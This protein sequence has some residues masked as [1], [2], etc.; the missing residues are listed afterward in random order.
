[1]SLPKRIRTVGV[2]GSGVMGAQIAAHCANAGLNVHLLDL[3]S[4]KELQPNALVQESLKKLTQMKPAPFNRPGLENVISIGNFEDDFDVLKQCDWI[5]EVVIERMDIKQS[6]MKKIDS[7]R[8]PNAIVSSN[9]SGLP[10]SDISAVASSELKQHFLGTHF[11][12]PPRYM[13]LLEL[14]PTGDT[15][16][17]VMQFMNTFCER[18]LGKGVVICKDTPNFI[19]NRIG[20]FS[21]ANVLP[22]FFNGTFRAEEIDVLNGTL[23]GFSKAASFRTADLA[24]LDVLKHVANNLLPKIEDDER[25]QVFELPDSFLKMVESGK[26]GNKSGAGFYKKVRTKTGTAYHVINPDTL[27]YEPQQETDQTF[28]NE[29]KRTSSVTD[30]LKKASFHNSREGRFIWQIQS[31]LLCYAAN[32]VP[33]ISDSIVAI[34]RALKW[35]FNWQL[36]PFERWDALGVEETVRRL[37]QDGREIPTLITELLENGYQSFYKDNQVYDPVLGK[38]VPTPS[39]SAREWPVSSIKKDHSVV[40]NTDSASAIDLGDGVVLFEFKTK[41]ATLNYELVHTLEKSLA[42]TENDFDALVIGHDGENFAY[43]AD[44]MEAMKAKQNGDHDRV[45]ETVEQFQRTAVKFRYAPFPVVAAPFGKTL[46]GGAEFVL[47]ADRV[48]AH[49]E[50]YMGLVEVGVGLIPAGGGTTELLRRAMSHIPEEGDE[51]PFIREVFKTIGL[52]KVSSSAALARD[53]N[54]LTNKDI[55]VMNRFDQLLIAKNQ[56][57]SMVDAGYQPPHKMPIKVLG[58][59]ALSALKLMLYV[60]NEAGYATDY[61]KVVAERVAFVLAGG[62]LS[63]PQFVEEEYLLKLEREAIFECLNDSRTHARIEHLFK[64]GKPLRN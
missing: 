48:V 17:E 15:L 14:I 26:T 49:H 32:R 63:E 8:K 4:D 29:I 2:L 3:K 30:R 34:D 56:A 42:I 22:H 21:M 46:G 18:V 12:N 61:D 53:M 9:T 47:Y 25:K 37:K 39:K 57:L 31:D 35:G 44:L 43:G 41:H 1:M 23:T 10:I 5:C 6:L 20:V 38:M 51:L 28:L 59:K 55:V 27:K 50:L 19:A 33:E 40:L 64:T 7:V 11:F 45:I 13:T 36:G 60:M 58:K 16:P 54:L 62:N 24:G 52:A